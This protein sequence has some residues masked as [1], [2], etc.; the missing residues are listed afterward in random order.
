M[1][2]L[3]KIGAL[4]VGLASLTLGFWPIWVACFGYLAYSLWSATKRRT[5]LV[6]DQRKP[7]EAPQVKRSVF[8]KRYIAAGFSFVLALAALGEGGTYAPWVFGFIGAA[9]VA[10]GVFNRGPS[11][12]QF[13]PVPDSILLRSRWLPI[14]WASVIEVK[15]G[16]QQMSRALSS[17]GNEMVM[18]VSSERVSVY[19]PLRVRAFSVPS[20][21]AKVAERLA[22]IARMLSARGAFA[23]PLDSKE[24]A[25]RMDWS[26]RAVDLALEYGMDGATALTSTPFDVLVLGP[27]GHMLES[28]AAYVVQPSRRPGYVLIPSPGRKLESQPL[29]WEA[30]E[31]LSEKHMPQTPDAYTSFLSGVCATK[32][33]GLGERLINGGQSGPGTVLVGSLGS[34]QVELTRPQLRAIVRAYG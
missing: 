5:V 33:E 30:L 28:A 27:S 4:L 11:L 26:L 34:T 20:A 12:S 21:E 22:P 24:A 16:T 29:L 32:G 8:K 9:I 14:S 25:A 19:L 3:L 6:R 15:F 1:G 17:V 18:T 23:L 31:T 7:R 2:W 13:R 10:S